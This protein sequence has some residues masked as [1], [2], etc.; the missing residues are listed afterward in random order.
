MQV[1]L[2]DRP[3]ERLTDILNEAEHAHAVYEERLGRTDPNWATW[4][5]RH[6]V[7]RLTEDES[8]RSE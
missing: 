4:Y 1:D 3:I 7:D 5:A 2:G 6:I 8:A